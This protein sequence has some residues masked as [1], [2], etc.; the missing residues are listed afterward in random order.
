L[1]CASAALS[2]LI[3]ACRLF[4]RPRRVAGR[5]AEPQP[6]AL[7]HA[8]ALGRADLLLGAPTAAH[9]SSC[10]SPLSRLPACR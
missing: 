5:A 6:G 8:S 4:R 10:V 7:V 1:T 3:A 9:V 2:L